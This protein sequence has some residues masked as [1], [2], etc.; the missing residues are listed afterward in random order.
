MLGHKKMDSAIQYFG[1]EFEDPP[2]NAEAIE[3]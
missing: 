1:V 3:I 2:T